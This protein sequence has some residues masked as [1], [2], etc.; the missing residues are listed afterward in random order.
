MERLAIA[1]LILLL[2]PHTNVCG[3]LSY[4]TLKKEITSEIS[5]QKQ[6]SFYLKME[7]GQFASLHVTE[8]NVRLFV[9][10]FDPSDSLMMI[11]DE[12]QM[13]DKEVV[14]FFSNTSGNYKIKV[15]WGFIKPFSGKYSIVLDKLETT[16]KTPAQKAAQLFDGWYEKN[17]P[18]AA[19]LVVKNGKI[20]FQA[21]NGLANMED[22][23]PITNN[24]VFEI[25]S[26]SKQFTG[27][28][29]A[30]LIDKGLIA[31]EDDIRKYIP[32]MPD[33]GHKITIANL[34]YHTSGI[35][36]T[37]DLQ[38]AGFIPE[39]IITLPICINFAIHQKNLKFTPGE[40]YNYSNT[41]YN[42]L[43]E[44]IT[45]ITKQS[46]ANWTKENIFQPLGMNSTFFKT[47]PGQLYKNK[48]LCYKGIPSGF[49]QR[50]N[51]WAATGASAVCTTLNDL[52]KW[53]ASFDT[54]Q[55][56]TPS[57]EKLL[58]TTGTLNN[59]TKTTYSFGNEIKEF[60]GKKEVIH[61]GLVLGYRTAIVRFPGEKLAVVYLS[62]DDNDATFQRYPKIIDLFTKGF[63]KTEKP[64]T[65]NIPS[66]DV[67]VKKL[68]DADRFVETIDV[69]PYTGTYFSEEL[70][71]LWRL[72][73]LNNR[74][75]IEIA[76]IPNIELKSSGNDSF[77]FL[78]FTRDS[79]N[80]VTGLKILG[81]G[82]EFLKVQDNTK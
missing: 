64:S 47:E 52:A 16:G 31:L 28:A 38:F 54:K 40:R 65:A 29:V 44:I 39:D 27:L 2:F 6:D 77:G 37:D 74:L 75:I 81:E 46:F 56:I 67:V 7:K 11:V 66:A 55:L 17:V 34:V 63:L 25:A 58:E 10:V 42:L 72:K 61:L 30:M 43:A 45:R 51:N 59:G 24:S 79:L 80:N 57:I 13:G 8:K 53:V 60:N 19:V 69:N 70:S 35:R 49:Q 41:N 78:K 9:E 36:S 15:L 14:S 20:L 21:T 3:Q 68:E 62:N 4:L 32:E 33:Y 1:V 5:P 82:I 12:N 22:D 76:R 26:C 50:P 71:C 23:I 48:V 73:N 18:G